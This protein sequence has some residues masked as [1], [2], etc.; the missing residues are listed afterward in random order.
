LERAVLVLFVGCGCSVVVVANGGGGGGSTFPNNNKLHK[1]GM[2]NVIMLSV[3]W[4]LPLPSGCD[5][6]VTD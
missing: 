2:S 5:V 1:L 6:V 3:K 4:F